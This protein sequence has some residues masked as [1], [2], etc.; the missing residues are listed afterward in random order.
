MNNRKIFFCAGTAGELIKLYPVMIYATHNNL[1]W[2]FI[3]TGQSPINFWRQWDDFSLDRNLAIG[4]LNTEKDLNST[5]Q[6]FMWFLKC[7]LL[8]RGKICKLLNDANFPLPKSGDIWIVHGDTLSTLSSALLGFRF[9]GLIAH[10]EAG[11]RSPSIISPFP[12]EITRRL[13]SSIARLHFP[14][15]I[16]ASNNLLK[17][18]VKGSVICTNGNT[19]YDSIKILSNQKVNYKIPPTPFAVANI[20][21]FENLGNSKRWNQIINTLCM[22]G[23]NLP[24]H[25]VLH[26]PTNAKLE[27]D[28]VTKQKLLSNGVILHPR[29][30]FSNFISLLHHSKF[31]ITDGG[32]NQEECSYIGKPC[33]IL[34]E[35]TERSEGLDGCCLLTNFD[36]KLIVDFLMQPQAYLRDEIFIEPSPSKTIVDYLKKISSLQNA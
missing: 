14:Q 15:D 12:E 25:L 24:I 5:L 13:V 21:R 30:T 29:L 16:I 10:V 33:M 22:A 7:I 23:R 8:T 36:K 28:P 18:S 32:S 26:P 6:A 35:G 11:L 19:L 3:F 4:L 1:D 17:S 34:R 31:V 2:R 20:H 9:D 27:K